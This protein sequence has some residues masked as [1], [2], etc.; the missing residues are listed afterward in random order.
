MLLTKLKLAV[1]LF[2]ALGLVGLGAG[3][4]AQG[5]LADRPARADQKTPP[6]AEGKSSDDKKAGAARTD[7]EI[8]QGAWQVTE[9]LAEGQEPPEAAKVKEGRL[10]VME[11]S[12]VFRVGDKTE[13]LMGYK[14]N[15]AEKPKAI[16]VTPQNGG[17][18]LPAIYHLAG[19]D[20]K[21]CIPLAPTTER[22]TE[23]VSKEGSKT[24]LLVL[25]R[26]PKAE[27]LDP[28]KLKA[29]AG[30][31]VK[32]QFS[33]NNLKQLALAMHNHHAVH[34]TLPPAAIY[35]KDGKPLLSWRVLILPY[36]EE[37]DLY[38]Q[39]KLD[40]P[41]DSEHNKKLLDKMPQI[42]GKEGK[43]T[44]YQ[45]FTGKG[46]IFE[47]KEGTKLTD[48]TDGTSNTI[49]MAEAGKAVPW[50]K[51]EDLPFDADKELPKLGGLFNGDFHAAFADGAVR[52][53]K[54]TI[55]AKEL[56]ALITYA[57]GEVVNFDQ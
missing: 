34:G 36:L 47:G 42:F 44:F 56:K 41:W 50:T 25:K 40:E 10:Y 6:K 46:T 8:I 24:L 12:I 28:K 7:L 29:D 49:L 33:A 55:D 18:P 35:D 31:A 48:I 9:M 39:F 1:A 2:V 4:L 38:D 23:F 51:P 5:A 3:I 30:E 16:D 26:D 13:G 53:L 54:G 20:L 32:R 21:L 45:V 11:E 37:K 52:F 43:E 17:M 22:P 57:G 19:D 27:K 15:P 14:L